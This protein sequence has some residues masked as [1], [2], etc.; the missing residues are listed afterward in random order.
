MQ[1]NRPLSICHIT[2]AGWRGFVCGEY[3][4]CENSL[5]TSP[6]WPAAQPPEIKGI[7]TRNPDSYA[8][9]LPRGLMGNLTS[10]QILA[11]KTH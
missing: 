9:Y 5:V 4:A 7:R 3:A 11:P 1:Y 2:W 8:S 6:L 10:G